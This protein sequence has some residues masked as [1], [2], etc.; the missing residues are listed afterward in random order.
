MIGGKGGT[1][2]IVAQ[3][4]KLKTAEVKIISCPLAMKKNTLTQD[5]YR[6]VAAVTELVIS[7]LRLAL[8]VK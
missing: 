1:R 7:S 4:S 2:I 5:T 8:I 3:P 6:R